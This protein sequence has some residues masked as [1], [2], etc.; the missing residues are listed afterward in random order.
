MKSMHKNKLKV[1]D[2]VEV[3][4]Y[5][6]GTKGDGIG[7]VGGFV[8]IIPGAEIGQT[9]RARITNVREKFAFGELA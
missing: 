1:G 2:E 5:S 9:V 6:L 7:N 8:V 3:E 4:I